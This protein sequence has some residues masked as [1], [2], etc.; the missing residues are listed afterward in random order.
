MYFSEQPDKWVILQITKEGLSVYRL[1][2]GW[3]GGYLGSDEWRLSSAIISFTKEGGYIYFTSA[4]GSIYKCYME[5]EGTTSY[6][7]S[8]YM[9]FKSLET[10]LVKINIMEFKDYEN[11]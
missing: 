1:L 7:Q 11:I 6:T 5:A 2:A 9:Y 3:Y 10:D 8:K 4:S